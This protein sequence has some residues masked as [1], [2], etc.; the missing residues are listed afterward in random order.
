LIV[1]L[2]DV[3]VILCAEM[4]YYEI[5]AA[6][7]VEIIVS[8]CFNLIKT[9]SEEASTL[10]EDPSEFINLAL[11]CT[12]KQRSMTPKTQGCKMLEAMV[13]NI[14]GATLVTTTFAV[15][16][17]NTALNSDKG[18]VQFISPEGLWKMDNDP[19]LQSTDPIIVSETC[20]VAL[21][22]IAYTLPRAGF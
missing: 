6:K 10:V 20:L 7:K 16:A 19:F 18:V 13:D 17:L 2:I 8:L 1:E 22:V 4:T 11:D 5:F 21:T 12:D 3:L 15:N 14:D 9:Q